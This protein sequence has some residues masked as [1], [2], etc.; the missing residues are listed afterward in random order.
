[1][2]TGIFI[3]DLEGLLYSTITNVPWP[4]RFFFFFGLLHGIHGY[5]YSFNMGNDSPIIPLLLYSLPIIIT[6][7]MRGVSEFHVVRFCLIYFPVMVCRHF[8]LF[9]PGQGLAIIKGF[10]FKKKRNLI[11]DSFP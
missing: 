10:L 2:T 6:A 9:L 5:A 8:V 11:N 3:L 7:F 4:C 1:M